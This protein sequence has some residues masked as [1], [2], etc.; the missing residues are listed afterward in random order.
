MASDALI[1]PEP[2]YRHEAE[3]RVLDRRQQRPLDPTARLQERREQAARAQIRDLQLQP[4]QPGVE[5]PPPMPVAVGPP[6]RGVLAG[7]RTDTGGGFDLDQPLE[8]VLV[9]PSRRWNSPG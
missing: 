8:R 5:R 2:R 3:R 9:C 4:P 6:L 7:R 1:Q